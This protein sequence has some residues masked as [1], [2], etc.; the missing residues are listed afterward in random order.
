M[1][2]SDWS[3]DVCS[4]DLPLARLL[5][6][7]RLAIADPDAVPAG[8]Y[9]KAALRY[10]GIWDSVAPKVARAENVRAALALV[11][12]S[13]A[14]FGIVYATDAKASRRV[15]V[16]GVFPEASPPAIPYPIALLQ[17]ANSSEAAIYR[18]FLI[19][20]PGQAI[21][22]RYGFGSTTR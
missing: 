5:G 21:F 20:R 1:R 14:P 6:E 7:G 3:S 8:L 12:R 15:K 4:S 19:S 10:L 18:Q 22:A 17:T 11:E 16:A 2:I 9:G 13:A